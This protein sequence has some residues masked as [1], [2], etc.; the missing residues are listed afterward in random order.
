MNKFIFSAVAM[1][2]LLLSGICNI[3]AQ[4]VTKNKPSDKSVK[5]SAFTEQPTILETPTGVL[6]GTL[7]FPL[8]KSPHPIV[9]IIAGSGPTN[10]DGNSAVVSGSNNSL[11]MLA[12]GLA[13]N[14]IASLRYDKRGV[15]E[16]AKALGKESDLRFDVYINDAVLWSKQLRRDK[17]FSTLTIIGQSEGSLVGMVAAQGKNADGFV[18]LAGLGRPAS[19]IILEQ[20]RP[21]LPPDLMKSTEEIM[22]LLAAGKTPESVPPSLNA[23]FRPSVLPYLMSW[24]RYDPAQEIAKLSVPV[25]IIQGTTDIQVNIQNAKL[26]AKANS[27]AQLLIVEGMNHVL[28]Q[29]PNE[30]NKQTKS[31]GDPSLQVVPQ[32]VTETVKFVK[33]FS[34]RDKNNVKRYLKIESGC[35]FELK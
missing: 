35:V 30:P 22:A 20:V 7:M 19:Q 25:L 18:S 13:G 21:R 15:G 4:S 34:A 24:I 29:V 9:L 6:H 17:R 2:L 10:R 33:K 23:L 3:H 32:L 14:G 28:K 16:S 12:E 5:Q 31:Y 11:K 8:S 1:M 26:L 27:S